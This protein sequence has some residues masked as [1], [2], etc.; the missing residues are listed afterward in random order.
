MN[1]SSNST[2]GVPYG[3]QTYN[4]SQK[5]EHKETVY[6]KIDNDT[7][8]KLVEMV[9]FMLR[10]ILNLRISLLFVLQFITNIVI[11]EECYLKRSG[12]KIKY[13]L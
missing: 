11:T 1:S 6:E 8:Y 4:E 13:K 9:C 3:V 5:N 2:L 7:R 10:G 12:R